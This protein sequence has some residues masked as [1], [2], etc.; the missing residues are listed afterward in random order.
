MQ[1]LGNKNKDHGGHT[2]LITLE[3]MDI[4]FSFDEI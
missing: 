3:H 2:Y 1:I 4:E